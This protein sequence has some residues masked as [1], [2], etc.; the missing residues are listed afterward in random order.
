VRYRFG[1]FVLDDKRFALTGPDGPVH[2]EPQVFE[3]LHHLI[4]NHDRVVTKEELLDEIWG[5]RFVSE[6]ALTSRVKAARRA[7]GDDGQAQHVIKTVHGRGYQFVVPLRADAGS[8]STRAALPR[9]RN[10][11]IGRDVDIARVAE[12]VGDAPMVTITGSGGIGKT[13][14]AL[15]VAERLQDEYADGAVFVDLSPVPPG[16]DVTRAVAEAAGVEGAASETIERV[17]SHLAHRPVLLVMDNCEHV[18]ERSSELVD[19]MLQQGGTAH[20]LATSREPLAVGGEHVWPLGP[21]HEDGPALFV[22]RARA[23]EP[24]VA[25]D[26]ADPAVTELCRR[27][28]GVPLAIELAAGQLRRFDLAELTRHLDDR[29]A[30]LAG[31]TAGGTPRH[32]TMET[33]IDW[34]Y[35]LLDGD[36][37][38]L[39]RQL[40]VFPASFDLRAV[41]ASAPPL[42]RT[43]PVTA[44]GQLVDKSLVVRQPGSGRYRLLETIRMFARDRLGECGEAASA[45]ERHRALVRD[46]VAAS[47]RLDRW[48]SGRLAAAF[49][50]DLEDARQAFRLSIAQGQ[51]RDALEVAIGA[52]FLWRNSLGCTEGDAWTEELLGLDLSLED[53]M[54]AHILRADVG[55]GRGDHRQMFGAAADAAGLIGRADDPAGACVASHFA[56]LAH[57]TDPEPARA[58]LAGT[59]DLARRSDDARL[60][61]LIEVFQAVAAIGAGR[62]ED[63]EEAR[64]TLTRLRGASSQDGYD[65]FILHW[66]GWML[67]LAEQ[68]AVAARAWMEQ[69]QDFLDRTGIVETWITSFSTVMCEVVEGVDVR[70]GLAR[71]LA[72]ADR[73]GYRA[74]ADCVLVLAFAELCA[75]RTE[76]AAALVGTAMHGRFNATAHYVLYRNVLDRSLRQRLEPRALAAA[77][78]QG[79]DRS[80]EEA[81][82]AYGVNR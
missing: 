50:A 71:T 39:L 9:L 46:R 38:R 15:A 52:S 10:V 60:V 7:V 72:L 37:Q 2:V 54:W 61:T 36:E 35:R 59:L 63:D 45:F 30:M 34:S 42:E 12:R 64:A 25:W 79:R 41:E 66:A 29:L 47:T 73:E 27:L 8:G 14:V 16:A 56:A 1:A 62:P 57:L 70:P 74:D 21:L 18:L 43:D 33:A 26:P 31:R 51:A 49:R 28:D 68:D 53:T 69:Q 6:S 82:A 22:E 19:R 13:T 67:A 3:L 80:A 78:A 76:A 44:F 23:A 24:R 40:S 32:G 55:E 11:P 5:D 81:L 4:R 48:L 17:A 58:H 20:V 65:S 77:T 75:D